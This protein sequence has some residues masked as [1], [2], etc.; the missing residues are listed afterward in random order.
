M[1]L[2]SFI[3]PIPV[4]DFFSTESDDEEETEDVVRSPPRQKAKPAAK[5]KLSSKFAIAIHSDILTVIFLY[6]SPIQQAESSDDE[7]IIEDPAPKPKRKTKTSE[8]QAALGKI[9][10]LLFDRYR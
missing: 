1:Q 4:F 6:L 7:E 10:C 9:D 2:V 5:R 8:K 3:S